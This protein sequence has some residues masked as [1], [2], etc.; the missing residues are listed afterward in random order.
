MSSLEPVKK[1]WSPWHKR[2]HEQF[3]FYPDLLPEG[4]CLL[5]SISGGQD[6]MALLKLMMDL[7]RIYKWKIVVWHGDHG[8]H[9]KSEQYAK[10]LKAWCHSKN[11]IFYCHTTTKLDTKNESEAREWR[12]NC[13]IRTAQELSNKQPKQRWKF[14]LTGHTATDRAETVILN[15]SRGSDL[16]GLSSLQECRNLNSEQL[17]IRPFLCFSR[18]DTA[19]ICKDFKLPIWLDPSNENKDITRNKIRLEILPILEEM[20][21]GSILRISD[22]SKRISHQRKEKDELINIAIDYI[23][24][25]NG[26]CRKKLK[27]LEVSTRRSLLASWLKGKGIKSLNAS[28]I[29][30]L[31]KDI[32]PNKAPGER[33]MSNGMKII[34]C[35]NFINIES[36]EK[37]Q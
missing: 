24:L 4:A 14:I 30:R 33:H 23:K 3:Q 18:S 13:L 8:W 29:E 34:W 1:P 21:P 35:R 2:L 17:L 27:E 32:G 11:L 5:L 25:Q 16:A 28:F 12:Y 31:A 26:L 36:I 37:I 7:K 20:Y 6:S 22:L 9:Q 10:E 15:L 19:Q